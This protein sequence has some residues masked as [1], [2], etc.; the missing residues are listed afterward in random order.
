MMQRP[1]HHEEWH[2]HVPATGER[3]LQLGKLAV[4]SASTSSAIASG[5][6]W[7]DWSEFPP[8]VRINLLG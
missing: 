1:P 8:T 5:P 3:L 4:V 2:I 6:L 7:L